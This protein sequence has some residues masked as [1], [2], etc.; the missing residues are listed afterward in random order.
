MANVA[1]LMWCLFFFCF[2]LHAASKY[3]IE[4]NFGFFF[5]S[6][7]VFVILNAACA[8][9]WFRKVLIALQ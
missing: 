7:V 9:Y 3:A 8:S 1:W 5:W 6:Q 2:S 4:N